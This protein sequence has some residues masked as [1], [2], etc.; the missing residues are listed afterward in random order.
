LAA[1]LSAFTQDPLLRLHVGRCGEGDRGSYSY[2]PR[3]Q[4]A[5]AGPRVKCKR[6]LAPGLPNNSSAL[7]ATDE[8]LR[9]FMTFSAFSR[10][11][12][13]TQVFVIAQRSLALFVNRRVSS[14][15][16]ASTSGFW[17]RSEAV[18]SAFKALPH[19]TYSKI[20]FG[21]A[22]GATRWPSRVEPKAVSLFE[23][24]TEDI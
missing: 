3:K 6:S 21:I 20:G 10:W 16:R 14:S 19:R 24:G 11:L 2:W 12:S 7:F 1:Q 18:E 4:S 23:P 22:T 9:E 13:I 15:I 17:A 5:V 8:P